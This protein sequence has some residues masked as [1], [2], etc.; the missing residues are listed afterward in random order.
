MD[1][2]EHQRCP[3]AGQ[4]ILLAM[5]KSE[6][7]LYS[8]EDSDNLKQLSFP[9]LPK[10]TKNLAIGGAFTGDIRFIA[11]SLPK[12]FLINQF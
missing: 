1:K 9:K 2:T 12:P 5:T 6:I 7:S 11:H 3:F 10:R 4:N 8:W